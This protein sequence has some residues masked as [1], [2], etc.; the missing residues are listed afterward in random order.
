[1]QTAG[2]EQ[3]ATYEE[4]QRWQEAKASY[5]RA[6]EH[7]P[8]SE[9]AYLG[10]IRVLAKESP[11]RSLG[12]IYR[13]ELDTLEAAYH[14]G[15]RVPETL[16]PLAAVYWEQHE[17]EQGVRLIE[18][19]F[20]RETDLEQAR[21]VLY[22]ATYEL[23]SQIPSDYGNILRLLEA[24]QTG[25]PIDLSICDRLYP[26]LEGAPGD[27]QDAYVSL[28]RA[29]EWFS[30]VDRLW[31][32]LTPSEQRPLRGS[33]LDLMTMGCQQAGRHQEVLARGRERLRHERRHRPEPARSSQ[34]AQIHAAVMAPAYHALGRSGQVTRA[35][36][37]ADRHLAEYA[38]CVADDPSLIHGFSD[39]QLV[40]PYANVGFGAVQCSRHAEAL[41][42]YRTAHELAPRLDIVNVYLSGLYLAVEGSREK[43]LRHLRDALET[44][45]SARTGGGK[46][47]QEWFRAIDLFHGVQEDA[48]FLELIDTT[49]NGTC[50]RNSTG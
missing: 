40:E 24:F 7:D 45:T 22:V 26:Y 20:R 30:T 29:D 39:D 5:R 28:G 1:M 42:Y 31:N 9:A 19:Y 23:H 17:K 13:D 12:D 44:A 47:V 36:R 33:Y 3:A 50:L 43:A 8:P 14:A 27:L 48:E 49:A 38:R 32:Q 37:T 11:G 34:L 41:R 16:L 18:E 46:I 25:T 10:L 4:E 6:L 35:L 15:L 2:L 21:L